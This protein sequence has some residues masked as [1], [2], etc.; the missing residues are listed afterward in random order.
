[1]IRQ[2]GQ[3]AR[4]DI[5]AR[6][7]GSPAT[8]TAIT[9][10]LLQEGL[11]EEH[12]PARPPASSRGRPRVALK[13]RG[14]AHIVAGIKV[15]AHSATLCFLDFEGNSRGSFEKPLPRPVLR[16][17]EMV[18]FLR[19]TLE[20]GCAAT[21]H[22]P[23]E[24]SALGLGVAGIVD[25]GR[26]L[27]YWSPILAER[28]VEL[29]RMLAPALP[30]PIFIDNDANLVA[31]AEHLFGLGR[32]VDDFIVI[33][34]E[35]GVGMGIVLDGRIY[36][37]S[38]GCGAEFGH[39]KVQL[40]GA[41]CRCGQRGCLEAYVADYALLR[42]AAILGLAPASSAPADQ[43]NSLFQAAQQGN[44]TA[45]SIFQRASR[46]F[47]LGLANVIN[48]FD[49][50]LIILSGER[51][52]FDYFYTDEVMEAIKANVLQIDAPLPEI[53]VHKW[54]DLMWA[55]GAGAFAMEGI[56]DIAVRE[57]GRNAQ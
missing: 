49:P 23:E 33:T 29:A 17:T 10:E 24:L 4:I 6:T 11:I 21:G 19:D 46:M 12:V 9:A 16:G 25:A 41:L 14:A 40:E 55:K 52:Q 44:E 15:A 35:Q 3:I 39:T 28:N 1:M 37:G 36:R 54:G 51:M 45:R 42:E 8:V 30:M 5:A 38:R 26:G 2:A 20:Q 22:R 32:D 34:V 31:K 48:I 43:L 53:Q 56:S 18:A 27:V 57:M 47:A 7:G 13:I 50:S